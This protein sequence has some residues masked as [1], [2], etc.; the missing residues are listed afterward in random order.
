MGSGR[1]A[2]IEQRIE[3][4][5]L[6]TLG[7]SL[8]EIGRRFGITK[9]AVHCMLRTSER[10]TDCCRCQ[11]RIASPIASRSDSS[12]LC[13]ECLEQVP[14]A[15]FPQVLRSLRVLVGLTQRQLGEGLG[16]PDDTVSRLEISA[17]AWQANKY[18]HVVDYLRRRHS[19]DKEEN[20]SRPDRSY[21]GSLSLIGDP[22]R[23]PSLRLGDQ[24][25]C[26]FRRG[27]VVVTNWTGA[28]IRWPRCR[29]LESRG[30]SG[31][32]VTE[33][34]VRAIRTESAL[35]IKWWWGVSTHTVWSWRKFFGVEQWGTE[36]S[37]RLHAEISQLGA[38][39]NQE[40]KISKEEHKRRR[41]AR[42]AFPRP[43]PQRWKEDG[44]KKHELELLG[45]IPDEELARR[46]GRSVNAV[47]V[48]RTRRGIT[49]NKN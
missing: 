49:R 29:L 7:L 35:A 46:I 4:T 18:S 34:L 8:A 48:M 47:R 42:R 16:V 1:K 5:R 19:Q 23:P 26:L 25:T 27:T 15:P 24:I 44:W 37:R 28:R 2:N 17:T 38:A 36:G 30:G 9:Q 3:V 14:E 45:S 43:L 10:A 41:R 40:R 13:W 32:L 20:Q 11:S 39:A 31:L 21:T 12:L 22:Y 6:R 33:E